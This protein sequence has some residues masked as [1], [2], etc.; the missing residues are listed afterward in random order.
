M[1]LLPLLLV[2]LTLPAPAQEPVPPSPLG[3]YCSAQGCQPTRRDRDQ[4]VRAYQRGEQSARHGRTQEAFRHFDRAARLVPGQPQYLMA[5]ELARQQMVFEHLQRGSL[6]LDR[7]D[8]AAAAA[9][10]R[11][12][13]EIDPGN[14]AA[15]ARLRQVAEPF[16]PPPTRGLRVLAESGETRLQPRPGRQSFRFRGDSREL[17]ELVA[18]AFEVR[19]SFDESVVTRRVRFEV[20]EVDFETAMRLANRVTRTFWVPLSAGQ[21]LLA[22]DTAENRR[23]LEPM[24]LRTFYVPE[25]ATAQELT[26]LLN[27]L[28]TLFDIRLAASQPASSTLTVRAPVEAVEAATR[29]LES[30]DAAR[31]QVLLDVKVFEVSHSLLRNIGVE[32]PLQFRML[33]LTA[34]ALQLTQVPGLQDLINQ[35]IASGAINQANQ[36]ALGALLQQILDQ[37]QSIFREP[38][39]TFGGG[40]T[41]M[42]LTIPAAGVRFSRDETHLE[43]VQHM[44]LRGSH[45]EPATLHVGARHPILNAS[46]APIFG[47]PE[48]SRVL[49]TGSF[50]PPFPSFTYED[51][52]MNLKATPFIRGE[53]EVELRLEL[54]VKALSGQVFN[55]VPVI[56]NREY[57]GVISAGNG[58]TVAVLGT[59]SRSEQR[60]LRGVPGF[61]RLPVLGRLGSSESKQ[62]EDNQL[63]ILLTPYVLSPARRQPSEVWL[64]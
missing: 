10:F 39:A 2:L 26:E 38:F 50:V 1:R 40:T 56:S 47:S 55:A 19:A 35:L 5:R 45:G 64:P 14:E 8:H 6:H 53:R 4:A 9:E 54:S 12:A 49:G 37:R 13:L 59:V 34:E 63:L 17:L 36:E 27:V 21:L 42:G 44:T 58:Q 48:L 57:S 23:R 60:S 20:E 62:V 33:H 3:L 32:L 24:A 22:A 43:R 41:L 46:F 29:F 25:A 15:L 7:R 61:S 52:G 18:R 31:P 30:M 51:L 28:R 16:L 11:R